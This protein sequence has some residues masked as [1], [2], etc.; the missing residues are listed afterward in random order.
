MDTP[1][2]AVTSTRPARSA[3][4]AGA[5]CT[6]P[7][8]SLNELAAQLQRSVDELQ[9]EVLKLTLSMIAER[10]VARFEAAHGRNSALLETACVLDRALDE[11]RRGLREG[12]SSGQLDVLIPSIDRAEKLGLRHY[13][14]PEARQHAASVERLLARAAKALEL[15]EEIELRQIAG[16][17]EAMRL[18]CDE[19]RPS[20]ACMRRG[21]MRRV[22]ASRECLPRV[23][24]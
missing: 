2:A 6:E 22:C 11:T 5:P 3:E 7:E 21:N 12:V 10:G 14:V 19:V 9:H 13:E 24:A 16:E 23:R 18:Q 8:L 15:V 20:Q 17:A 4:G 1:E